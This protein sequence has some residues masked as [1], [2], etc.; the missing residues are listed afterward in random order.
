MLLDD[1]RQYL[2]GRNFRPVGINAEGIFLN[3]YEKEE[4][5][6]G[7]LLFHCPGGTEFTP[8]QYKNI[9]RQVSESLQKNTDKKVFIQTLLVTGNVTLACLMNGREEESWIVDTQNLK[10]ILFENQKYDFGGIRKGLEDLL[11]DKYLSIGGEAQE[12]S[13][14]IPYSV[15]KEKANLAKYISPCN[16]AIVILNILVFLI[17]NTL[18]PERTGDELIA[19]G[20][21]SW[22]DILDSQEYYRLVTYMFLHSNVSHLANNMI[23]L[24]FIG[25][26]L[27]RAAGKWRYILMYFFSG[28]LAGAASIIYNM[29]KFND[30]VSIGAS[31]AIFGVVGAMV[32]VV[33][34][35]RGR[36]ENIGTR[37]LAFF[38]ILS[39]YG[40]LT[41]QGVDN[42]AHVGG[43]VSG[44]LLAMV[45]YRKQKKRD[46]GAGI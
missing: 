4:G 22:R 2:E 20:A 44:F 37:Q 18:L 32:Y 30:I 7:V 35:N 15:H 17:V 27:E 1:I 19:R 33:V 21:L 31:G 45:L 10:L 39:L 43:L 28:V 40:G 46:G 16:T 41:S 42:I 36:L 26:N 25:D 5:L 23:V 34:V 38:V 12:D 3:I 24:L 8:Q 9:K 29:V 13:G 14:G 6:L 11:L